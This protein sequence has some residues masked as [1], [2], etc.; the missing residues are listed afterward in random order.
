[1]Q[2][3]ALGS[4]LVVL[5]YLLGS[6]PTGYLIGR[7][8]QN[9]DIREHGSGSTGA[10]NV[11][12]TLGKGPAIAVLAV[13]IVK[14]AAAVG[15]VKLVYLLGPDLLPSVWQLWLIVTVGLIAI[16]GHSRSVWLS[17]TGGKSVATS[18]GVIMVINPLAA[19]ITLGTFGLGLA[20]TRIVSLSS[21]IGAV[22]LNVFMLLGQPLPYILF[23]AIAGIYVFV[24]HTANIKRLIAGTEP[25]I[26]QKLPQPE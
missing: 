17:F 13:D 2:S 8:L 7:Y 19:L 18:I 11:L 22:A 9:I 26:G 25:T 16:L 1:M 15:L 10:T 6:I 12:R 24:R 23:G 21:L 5:A 20:I 3:I 14:G 4:L